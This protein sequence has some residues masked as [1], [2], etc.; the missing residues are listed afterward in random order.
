MGVGLPRILSP[1]SV[2]VPRCLGMGGGDVAGAK[3]AG[4][5]ITV[6]QILG[7]VDCAI[8]GRKIDNWVA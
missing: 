1:H 4:R 7:F 2:G 8:D 3:S 5:S 6:E